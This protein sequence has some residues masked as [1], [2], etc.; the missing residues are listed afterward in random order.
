MSLSKRLDDELD[1]LVG[2][3]RVAWH[4]GDKCAAAEEAAKIIDI[5]LDVRMAYDE[6]VENESDDEDDEGDDE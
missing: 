3:L 5:M 2:A 6:E 4:D 1:P